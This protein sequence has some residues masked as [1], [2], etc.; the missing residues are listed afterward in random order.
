MRTPKMATNIEEKQ[1]DFFFWLGD[2][3]ESYTEEEFKEKQEKLKK[4]KEEWLNAR[5]E[6]ST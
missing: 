1:L 2:E 3:L 5:Y 4:Q 6:N